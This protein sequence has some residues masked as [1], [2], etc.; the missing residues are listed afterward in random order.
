MVC[1]GL[2]EL[3]QLWANFR[4]GSSEAMSYAFIL[5][6]IVGD[7]F[8]VVGCILIEASSTQI[9]VAV[10]YS[11]VTV[12][13]FL[14]HLYY[15][16]FKHR[17]AK[18][19]KLA[20]ASEARTAR[21]SL[22]AVTTPLLAASADHVGDQAFE[23]SR[24]AADSTRGLLPIA[25]KKEAVPQ[26]VDSPSRRRGLLAA[27]M[28]SASASSSGDGEGDC[29]GHVEATTSMSSSRSRGKSIPIR[30]D[31]S[32]IRSLPV[33]FA[34]DAATMSALQSTPRIPMTR[35]VVVETTVASSYGSLR[36][37]RVPQ[38]LPK[39]SFHVASTPLAEEEYQS[40]DV[41][42]GGA[43][44]LD[45]E[46]GP[47]AGRATRSTRRGGKKAKEKAKKTRQRGGTLAVTA[48]SGAAG[49][50]GLSSIAA[51]GAAA[52]GALA[53]ATVRHLALL[54]L[55]ASEGASESYWTSKEFVGAVMG[56]VM[57]CIY[58]SS[59]IPQIIRNIQRGSCEGLSLA[60]F[61]LAIGGNATFA[62]QIL[63]RDYHWSAIKNNI[64]WLVDCIL[65]LILDMVILGQFMYHM[66]REAQEKFDRGEGL[67]GNDALDNRTVDV[68]MDLVPAVGTANG[69][70]R[71]EEEERSERA[72]G[73][74][75]DEG[76]SIRGRVRETP[77][78]FY[79]GSLR[80]ASYV[81]HAGS[82]S[83]PA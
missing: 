36:S 21:V 74:H 70:D 72:Y 60:M 43:S 64:A 4:N 16:E 68:I 31:A 22:D 28:A 50:A 49:L 33:K 17:F 45:Y 69:N 34:V 19:N 39:V 29:R 1:W 62:A 76:R 10:L 79:V 24:P 5:A 15:N 67:S 40:Y 77:E 57:T 2:A 37:F 53:H 81:S 38:S 26:D 9:L 56:W 80:S 46:R 27:A 20:D 13:L 75:E 18:F 54:G 82:L 23:S 66:R 44:G 3:P 12:L 63:F 78:T 32:D 11:S 41:E 52:G 30:L 51:G 14:Q 7:I 25:Q 48:A 83:H 71:G 42:G 58:L 59:R 8:N 55:T 73:E 61:L 6:W 65:C 35:P 47:E